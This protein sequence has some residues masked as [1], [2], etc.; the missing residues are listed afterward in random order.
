[1]PTNYPLKNFQSNG[2]SWRFELSKKY[3]NLEDEYFSFQKASQEKLGHLV[4]LKP[5]LLSTFFD[6]LATD[7]SIINKVI[8]L[9]TWQRC[10]RLA[11]ASVPTVEHNSHSVFD[12]LGL[13]PLLYACATLTV[14]SSCRGCP[15]YLLGHSLAPLAEAA[16]LT[17][18]RRGQEA[19]DRLA[20]RR[21]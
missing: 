20:Q 4:T 15:I 11:R 7:E 3:E 19:L 5:N 13:T 6:K 17:A 1:M 8:T 21:R 9:C 10:H 18:E 2:M 14:R 16:Q 12:R